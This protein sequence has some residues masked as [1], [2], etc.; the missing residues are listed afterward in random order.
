MH[1]GRPAPYLHEYWATDWLYWPNYAPRRLV[2]VAFSIAEGDWSLLTPYDGALSDVGVWD[3]S[4]RKL[5]Y[6]FTL[7]GLGSVAVSYFD[8][9]SPGA[10]SR[11][12]FFFD[13]TGVGTG[14][15]ERFMAY[16]TSVDSGLANY[17]HETGTTGAFSGVGTGGTFTNLVTPATWAQGGGA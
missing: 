8:A 1:K 16:E 4:L 5:R 14:E 2:L 10:D 3:F 17:Y 15:G 12:T 9:M 6:D 13:L 11:N 7:T